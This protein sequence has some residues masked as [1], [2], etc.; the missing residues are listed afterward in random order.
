VGRQAA[1]AT[2][3]Q[4]RAEILSYSRSRGLFAGVSLDGSALQ[5]DNMAN[6]SFYYP[7]GPGST[8]TVP[9][10]AI[11]LV[12]TIRQ[13]TV[14]APTG[15]VANPAA[16]TPMP[17]PAAVPMAAASNHVSA[18][19]LRHQLAGSAVQLN[20][21]LDENWKRYLALPP[22]IFTGSEPTPPA[23]LEATLANYD[24][25]A[26]NADYRILAVR[27]EFRSTHEL[28]QKYAA[29]ALKGGT[30]TLE[31]PPPPATQSNV[32]TRQRY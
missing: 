31:L 6:T 10:P 9:E 1:A 4:L 2:D 17:T 22:Q 32:N 21:M 26:H 13:L 11:F 3:A 14:A 16:V 5:I 29:T 25:V 15:A 24:L 19:Q 30:G 12:N 7:N 27:P 23:A 28:L 18:D 8:A 20:T